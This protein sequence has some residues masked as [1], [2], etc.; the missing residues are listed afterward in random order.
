MNYITYAIPFF[1]LL[2][3]VEYLWGHFTRNQTYRLN[4]TLNS[5]SM[6]L[7][8]RVVD[9][10]R[11]GFAGVV[12]EAIVRAAGVQQINTEPLWVWIAAFVAYD[13]CYYWK[14]RFG[15]EWRI[16]WAS[17][18]AH[19]QSEEF[20][21]STALR[22]TGTDYIGFVFYIP[23]YLVGL[24]VEVIITVGSLNLIYQFWVHTEHIR[25]LGPIE[26][27]FVTPSNHRVHHAKNPDYIDKNYGGVF[28]L[29]DRMFGT[30]KDEQKDKPCYYGITHAL[31]SW[32]PIWANLHMWV[33]TAQLAWKTKRWRDKFTIWFKPPS[34]VPEDLPREHYDWQAPRFDPEITG[35]T[36]VY[37]FANYWI[38]TAAGLAAVLSGD[39]LTL[40]MGLIAFGVVAMTLFNHGR[41]LESHPTATL[42][43]V[44]R[45]IGLV[46]IGAI[47]PGLW[48]G[49]PEWLPKALFIYSGLSFLALASSRIMSKE[50][51]GSIE[52]SRPLD[53]R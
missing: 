20:N 18:V 16:L 17:H 35:F 7:L 50:S 37:C 12:I 15:H 48:P 2:M 42:L 3:L 52:V 13:F 46:M 39:L 33:E 30:F 22:Q 26:W 23:L 38:V 1:V 25:R 29:W 10:L 36:R 47:T 40:P 53:A 14:H 28:I 21:L 49:L 34:W 9:L 45:L 41:M 24:P 31:K 32:N 19:H 43:E 11:L 4:D 51:Y 27:V 5:L 6:G 8:S 44:V